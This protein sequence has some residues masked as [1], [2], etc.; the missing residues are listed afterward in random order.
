VGL[1]P[2]IVIVALLIGA[3]IGGVL[4]IIISVPTAAVFQEVIQ[5]WSSKRRSRS[6]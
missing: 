4:G 1:H 2:V 6:V 3:E 5:D